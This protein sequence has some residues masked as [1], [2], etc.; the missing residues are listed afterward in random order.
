[1]SLW[2]E[3][4]RTLIVGDAF[5]T[6]KQE[7]AYAVITQRPE[8]HGPPMYFTTDWE[9]ARESVRRLAALQ[10]ELVITGHGRPLQGEELRRGLTTLAR[11]FDA[12]ARPKR[13][14]YVE[15]EV[16]GEEGLG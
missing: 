4:D 6:T 16:R 12:V 13:G 15:G 9:S 11:N 2:R 5:I 10:P 1:V 8:L 7:S 3:D 14:R